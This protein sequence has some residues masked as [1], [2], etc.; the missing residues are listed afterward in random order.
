M[1][2]RITKKTETMM[3]AYCFLVKILSLIVLPVIFFIRVIQKKDVASWKIKLSNFSLPENFN[4]GRKTIMIHGVS[5]GEIVSLE[6]LFKR[7]KLIFPDCNLVI[8]TG[9]DRKS[10][11]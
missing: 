2:T 3:K 10:V 11:V 6:K 9:T 5:V 1:E 7:V 4:E 8:T